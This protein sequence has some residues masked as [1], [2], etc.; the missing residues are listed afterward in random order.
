[1]SRRYWWLLV[2]VL[3]GAIIAGS[4]LAVQY[5]KQQ[6]PDSRENNPAGA[7]DRGE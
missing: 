2:A 7:Y 3:I 6:V 1:V 4:L 5:A